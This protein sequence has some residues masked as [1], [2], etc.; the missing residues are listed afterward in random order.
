MTQQAEEPKL[1]LTLGPLYAL[2][3]GCDVYPELSSGSIVYRIADRMTPHERR[4][5]RTVGPA[6]LDEMMDERPP[7]AVIVG[8]ERRQFADLEEPLRRIVPPE[9]SRKDADSLE[10]YVRP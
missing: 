5:T 4:I 8:V 10:A 1:V 9:W 2:E 6:T 7:A 3:A